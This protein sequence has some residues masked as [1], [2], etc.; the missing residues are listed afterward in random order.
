MDNVVFW[1]VT[2]KLSDGSEVFAV[3]ISGEKYDCIT[4][5]NARD[6]ADAM[7]ELLEKHTNIEAVV[8]EA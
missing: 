8:M 3:E 4:E 1:I 2:E 7:V 6:F 5:Q